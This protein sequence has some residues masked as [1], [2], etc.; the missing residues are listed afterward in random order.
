[1]GGINVV[2][3]VN[4]AVKFAMM[5]FVLGRVSLIKFTMEKKVWRL[6]K[7]NCNSFETHCGGQIDF[8]CFSRIC[9]DSICVGN[10]IDIV[11]KIIV[12]TVKDVVYMESVCNPR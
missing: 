6:Y 2:A 12:A 7:T 3:I 9:D 5:I 8:E 1:M 11:F 10:N 4:A